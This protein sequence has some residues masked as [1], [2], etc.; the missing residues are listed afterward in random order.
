MHALYILLKRHLSGEKS[1]W[2]PIGDTCANSGHFNRACIQMQHYF[3]GVDIYFSLQPLGIK[4]LQGYL[5]G[6][7]CFT[8]FMYIGDSKG[9]IAPLFKNLL[10]K[11][12]SID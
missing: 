3:Y 4:C 1:P 10:R 9:A 7:P 2:S 12:C 5:Y 8:T 6:L 11:G